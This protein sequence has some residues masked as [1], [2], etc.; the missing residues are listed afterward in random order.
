LG[1]THKNHVE[2]ANF[3]VLKSPDVPSILV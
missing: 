2:H 1:K 3:V